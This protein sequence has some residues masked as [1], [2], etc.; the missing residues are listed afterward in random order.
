[1]IFHGGSTLARPLLKCC[2]QFWALQFEN[3]QDL[4]GRVQL[5][6]MKM[7]RG[8]EHLFYEKRLRELGLVSLEKAER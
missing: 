6:A 5:S 1:M 8:L 7:R 3:D 4:L 2:V